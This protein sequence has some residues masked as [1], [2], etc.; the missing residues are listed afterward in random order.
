[1]NK[2][3]VKLVRLSSKEAFLK[4]R[5]IWPI[6]CLAIN[7]N[8]EVTNLFLRH[9]SGNATKRWIE[10][11]IY[12]LTSIN[13]IEKISE[14]WD[15]IETREN[16]IIE[17]HRKFKKSYKINYKISDIDFFLILWEKEDWKIILISVFLN[18]LEK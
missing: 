13:L 8:F 14:N 7:K 11:I 10:E 1:M 17:W 16:I 3:L 15:L 6:F 4:L 5:N 9:I 18:F 12:R 2:K